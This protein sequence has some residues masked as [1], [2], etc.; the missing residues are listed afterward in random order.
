MK[1]TLKS[2]FVYLLE[3]SELSESDATLP[4]TTSHSEQD[5]PFNFLLKWP[6]RF[7]AFYDRVTGCHH[8]R[9]TSYSSLSS[10]E[11]RCCHDKIKRMQ[12]IERHQMWL[13]RG[14]KS[15]LESSLTSYLTDKGHYS[16]QPY[17]SGGAQLQHGEN[18]IRQIKTSRN[19]RVVSNMNSNRT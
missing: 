18:A 14:Y 1:N 10:R 12:M 2:S 13:Q 11:G 7:L 6:E 17:E 9:P 4:N 15:V 8:T 19:D 3:F 5:C 16:Y